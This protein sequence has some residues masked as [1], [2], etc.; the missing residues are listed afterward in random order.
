A[1]GATARHPAPA[2]RSPPL[3]RPLS[4]P[5]PA[6]RARAGRP[7][8]RLLQPL[9]HLG[10]DVEARVGGND[11]AGRPVR[12]EDQRVVAL[13]TQPLDH[14]VDARLDGLNQLTLTLLALV[15]ELAGALLQPLLQLLQLL[16]LCLLR[17]GREGD[18][19]LLERLNGRVELLPQ[20]LRLV[21]KA[22]ILLLERGLGRGVAG[23]L[24]E[25]LLRADE[26][27]LEPPPRLRLCPRLGGGRSSRAEPDPRPHC[28][29]TLHKPSPQEKK[30]PPVQAPRPSAGPRSEE[31]AQLEVQLEGRSRPP[32]GFGAIEA[33]R[34]A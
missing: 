22:L 7:L 28:H 27:D 23:R 13:G 4:P 21:L 2:R 25:N 5:T 8:L 29:Y 24:L 17:T 19:L 15:L 9:D 6:G 18:G 3:R 11:V 12:V 20:L 32:E 31:V 1:R 34:P 30:K 10:G 14:G 16:L 33:V 26:R